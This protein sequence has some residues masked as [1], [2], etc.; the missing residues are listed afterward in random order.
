MC[1]GYRG[2]RTGTEGMGLGKLGRGL[3]CEVRRKRHRRDRNV[4]EDSRGLEGARRRRIDRHSLAG[5]G[6][7]MCAE[8][9]GRRAMAEAGWLG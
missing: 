4:R 1:R 5:D 2:D 3:G 9:C 7:G 6:L 8:G